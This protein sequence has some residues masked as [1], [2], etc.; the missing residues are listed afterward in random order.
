MHSYLLR[1][2]NVLFYD[3]KI[4]SGYKGGR[5]NVFLHQDF[6]LVFI[7]SKSREDRQGTS[8]YNSTEIEIVGKVIWF[9]TT[10]LKINPDKFGFVSPYNGQCQRLKQ[11]FNENMNQLNLGENVR[12]I[13][14]WQGR[15]KDIMVFS[16]VRG[17]KKGNIGFLENEKRINVALTRAKHGLIIVGNAD[18]LRADPKWTILLGVFQATGTFVTGFDEAIQLI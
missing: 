15:E 14:S 13:D 8:F 10:Q 11:Y 2:P 18:T 4:E 12:S 17:N 9:L 16:A 7:D 1:V 3:E 5:E 6:P